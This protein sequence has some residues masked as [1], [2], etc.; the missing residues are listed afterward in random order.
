MTAQNETNSGESGTPN[1]GKDLSDA[2]KAELGGK[3]P[4]TPD[5]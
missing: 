1:I 3:G 2:D 5:G 4:G